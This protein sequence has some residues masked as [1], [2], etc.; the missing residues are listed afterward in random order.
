MLTIDLFFKFDTI[1]K[2]VNFS[3][4][5]N[6]NAF[7]FAYISQWYYKL[8]DATTPHPVL[9]GAAQHFSIWWPIVFICL[10]K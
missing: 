7:R 6:T 4:P 1:L 5:D 2:D 3:G 10:R 9:S 8:F